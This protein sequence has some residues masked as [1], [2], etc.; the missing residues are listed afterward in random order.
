MIQLKDLLLVLI[1][2]K[3]MQLN[4]KKLIP[5]SLIACAI[6]AIIVSEEL[7]SVVL[8]LLLTGTLP[9]TGVALPSWIMI[10][11]YVGLVYVIV[12]HLTKSITKV[13]KTHNQKSS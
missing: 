8:R 4:A 5:Y 1:S 9:G 12:T 11:F 7:A 2:E 13:T 3:T 10:I 6:L